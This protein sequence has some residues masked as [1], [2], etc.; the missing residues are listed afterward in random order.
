MAEKQYKNYDE[1]F[2]KETPI[3]INYSQDDSSDMLIYES[4]HSSV[5]YV[6][7]KMKNEN[8]EYVQTSDELHE[9]FLGFPIISL[10]DGNGPTAF[11]PVFYYSDYELVDSTSYSVICYFG[12]IKI[13]A[14]C[15][16]DF[17]K[18]KEQNVD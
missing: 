9:L 17:E 4:D 2:L 6:I 8:G 14:M 5:S 18:F 11:I 13:F 7:I 16:S 10:P 3:V 12:D 15:Q 1:R